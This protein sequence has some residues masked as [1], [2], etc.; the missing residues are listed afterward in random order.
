MKPNSL[1]DDI[2]N[3]ADELVWQRMP[4][5]EFEEKYVSQLYALSDDDLQDVVSKIKNRSFDLL[6]KKLWTEQDISP[7]HF[8]DAYERSISIMIVLKKCLF[9]KLE[10]EQD[11]RK[12]LELQKQL[13]FISLI[14]NPQLIAEKT[15]LPL[16]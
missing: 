16:K 3:I 6:I 11:E 5:E 7:V 4:F 12:Q 10:M 2:N 1:I 9:F 14:L 15:G 8:D 13:G